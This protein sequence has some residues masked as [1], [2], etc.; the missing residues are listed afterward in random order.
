MVEA[1]ATP[2]ERS[3]IMVTWKPAATP[4][5]MTAV[6][7]GWGGMGVA[8]GAAVVEIGRKARRERSERREVMVGR[9]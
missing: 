3:V 4:T 5:T 1:G 8:G 2:R 9:V 7:P 6:L